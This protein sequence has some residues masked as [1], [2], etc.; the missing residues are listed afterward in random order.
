MSPRTTLWPLEPHTRG[1]HEVLKRYLDAW[2]PI[3]GSWAGRI[4]FIDGFAGPGEYLG[5]E[6]G[7]P[8]IAL[9]T[10]LDHRS[11]HL[12]RSQV[13]FLFIEK[14]PARAA[15]LERLVDDH[16]PHPSTGCDIHVHCGAFDA[17]MSVVLDNLN[18]TGARLAPSFVML[19]PFGVSDT[20]MSIIRRILANPR[21]EVYVS[22]MYEAMNRFKE[23]PEFAPHLDE[24]F[25]SSEWCDGIGIEDPLQ[26]KEFFYGLYERQ[27]RAAGAA[28][29]V[30]FELYEGN[31]LVY[32][33]FFATQSTKGSDRMKQ[34]IWKVD[35][36]GDFAFRGTHSGQ[37]VLGMEE[38]DLRPL[39]HV[40]HRRF[41]G[42]DWI[43]IEQV[44]EFVASDQTDFHTGQVKGGALKPM[45]QRGEVEVD[46]ST[47]KRR[48]TYPPG[49]RLRFLSP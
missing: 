45:E 31:R 43:T 12:V 29:V 30:R 4:I 37:L 17:S 42:M 2:F 46:E 33:I 26:R 3:L 8:L 44:L 49:T 1:K 28:Q 48:G 41:G 40:L 36:F 24:L 38:P 7:S 19:D 35:P 15:H 20:P 16:R 32:A 14:D 10:Y 27:L 47:R 25:G 21:C 11:R 5:G 34:A 18:A 39:Q 9:R 23:T 6:P 13:T 22:F